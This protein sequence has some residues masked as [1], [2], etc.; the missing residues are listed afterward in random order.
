VVPG[1]WECHTHHLIE[2]KFYGDRLGRLWLAYGVT[3]LESFGDA[4]Y[5]A[6]ETR[7]AFAAGARVGPRFFATGEPIDGE[8]IY[9]STLRP[10]TSNEQ[11]ELSLSRAQA[12]DYDMIKTYVR[13]PADLQAKVARFAH[14]QM[15][16]W[17]VSHYMLPGMSF[18]MDGMAHVSATA[19]LGFAY[20]RTAAGVSYKDVI[21]IFR[22]PGTFL[23]STT[24]NPSLYAEDPKM[25][26]DN[27]LLILN[28]PW[29]QQGLVRKRNEAVSG[30]Q[31]LSLDTLRKEEATVAAIRR[32]GGVVLAGTD[33]PLDNV[34]TALHLNLRAQV[35]FG[36]PP[37][38]ALESATSLVAKDLG[39]LEP[40]KLADMVFV[41][42]NPLA[43]IAD[44]ANVRR[45][46]INGRLHRISDLEAPFTKSR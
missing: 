27:R 40:G 35:K 31:T 29:D 32:G 34:A 30:D 5:R 26:E 12:L 45:V 22:I 41:S 6:L 33:S 37:W 25:V 15:G 44:L 36:L 16:V 28:T 10:T 7:E 9:Y 19:R 43:N 20:T 39:T 11:L 42:G 8:R 24:L 14:E 13:L 21:D 38:Q 1:L 3:S 17:A 46:M 18:G 4:G 23:V 2:G